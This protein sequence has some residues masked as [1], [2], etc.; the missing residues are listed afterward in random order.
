MRR[1]PNRFGRAFPGG[2]EHTF[3]VELR[4]LRYFVAVAEEENLSRAAVRLHVSQPPLS[5]QMLDLEGE[6]GVSLF[7]RTAKS[8]ALTEAGRVFLEEARAVLE[9]AERAVET[10]R[11]AARG[12]AGRVVAGYAPSLTA[13]LLP[14]VLRRFEAAHPRAQVVL[15][16]V[17]T[18]E[19][20][21]ALSAGL[22]H[23]A[24]GVSPGAS[25]PAG[26]VWEPLLAYPVRVAAARSHR[27]GSGGVVR[28]ADL[29]REPLQVYSA[30][31]YPEY[32]AWLRELMR[33]AGVV[34]RMG[35]EHDSASSLIA[36]VE[37]GRGAAVVPASL[38]CLAGGRLVLR[39]LRPDPGPLS[40]GVAYAP[41]AAFPLRERFLDALRRAARDLIRSGKLALAPKTG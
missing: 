36:A 37:S 9:Q 34:P 14:E 7:R 15:Q 8:L 5:R 18:D 1:P 32:R 6:L 12:E 27:L 22:L 28:M 24:L 26:V 3:G 23:V 2:V 16:D 4:H 10:V 25:L 40:L 20:M 11:A 30:R 33:G 29:A 21:S 19:M 38:A 41:G 13:E 31:G 35:A 17:N 39:R